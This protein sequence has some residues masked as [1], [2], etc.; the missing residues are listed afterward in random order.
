MPVPDKLPE[1]CANA[2]T[3]LAPLR[4]RVPPLMERSAPTLATPVTLRTPPD[5]DRLLP[6]LSDAIVRLI[7]GLEPL[8]AVDNKPA[9]ID[10]SSAWAGSVFAFQLPARL[11]RLLAASPS[12]SFVAIWTQFENG[13]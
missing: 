12:Q 3:L 11:Q 6:E 1:L 2:L 8:N 13:I 7:R 5:T 9:D 4:A 10:I